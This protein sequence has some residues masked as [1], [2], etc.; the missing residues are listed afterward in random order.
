M[1]NVQCVIC[2]LVRGVTSILASAKTASPILI[3]QSSICSRKHP[4]CGLDSSSTPIATVLDI[5]PTN[6]HRC[7]ACYINTE[8]HGSPAWDVCLL[9]HFRLYFV[10]FRYCPNYLGGPS[11]SPTRP[12][13]SLLPPFHCARAVTA[14][15]APPRTGSLYGMPCAEIKGMVGVQI[16]RDSLPWCSRLAH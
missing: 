13:P 4:I 2:T 3:S 14:A 5:G 11:A 8:H 16:S 10:I 6:P 1:C 7:F 9:V 12:P 15:A